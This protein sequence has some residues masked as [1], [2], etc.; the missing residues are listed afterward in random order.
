MDSTLKI[1]KI[2]EQMNYQLKLLH[3][4]VKIQSS[5]SLNEKERLE[6]GLSMSSEI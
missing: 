1:E 2:I 5:N 4:R 6:N 3:E